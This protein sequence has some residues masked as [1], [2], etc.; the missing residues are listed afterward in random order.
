MTTIAFSS[1]PADRDRER[2]SLDSLTA[3]LSSRFVRLHANEIA[4][5]LVSAL[6]EVTRAIG[7]DACSLVE[8][9][10]DRD[11]SAML[12]WPDG[13]PKIGP[14][15]RM[16]G[17]PRWL[18]DR[19]T[20]HEVVAV[21]G[22]DDLP[23]EE[24]ALARQTGD[25]SGLAV[26]V[27]VA[28]QVACALVV[29]CRRAPRQWPPSVIER[30]RTIAELFAVTVHRF[31][32]DTALRASLGTVTR[33]NAR[34][35]ADNAYLRE[36]A[37]ASHFSDSIVGESATLRLA[38]TRLA[39]VAPMDSSV[40]LLGETGTG[41]ELFARALHDRSRRRTRTLVRVNCAA[42]PPTLVESE[43]F[44]HEKGAFTGAASTRLGRFELADGGTIFLDEIGDLLPE[45]QVKLLRVLQEGE[46]ERVGS[47]RTKRVN[48]RVIAATHRDLEAD[49]AAGRFRADLYYRLSVYPI[50]LPPLRERR[51]DIPT[52]VWFLIHQRQREL[53]RRI[54]T[55]PQATMLALQQH[56][57]PGNVRELENVIERALIHSSGDTLAARRD[58]HP[59]CAADQRAGVDPTGDS[60]DAIE[61]THIEAV[62]Q[63]SRWRISGANAAAERLGLHPNTLRFRLKKLGIVLP[64]R[65]DRRRGHVKGATTDDAAATRMVL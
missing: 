51:D 10:E 7:A 18:L 33:R 62:L 22:V 40:L 2:P 3:T 35:T 4:P 27:L 57:W 55:V 6:H 19:L 59:R 37:N 49:V 14:L 52:L 63:Q 60:L 36:E 15:G 21:S 53:G 29:W 13:D 39:Q 24:R 9:G 50:H 58:V 45:I 56:M 46:F 12:T 41:K 5:A 44:G 48:V 34:L 20:R 25:W 26:P 31:R 11:V 43:L 38:L 28:E 65:R 47:S 54:T 42:L 61:R 23:A 8:F 32:N 1:T 16:D 64:N 17:L 30:L